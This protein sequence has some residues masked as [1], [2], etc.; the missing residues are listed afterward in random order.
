M[1]ETAFYQSSKLMRQVRGYG[2]MPNIAIKHFTLQE[3]NLPL[4]P[5]IARYRLFYQGEHYAAA[6]L[7]PEGIISPWSK[8]LLLSSRQERSGITCP[9]SA[10]LCTAFAFTC[11]L[12]SFL[13]FFPPLP[14]LPPLSSSFLPHLLIHLHVSNAWGKLH[15]VISS[16]SKLVS[17]D[18][19]HTASENA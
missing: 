7:L 10:A 18:L 2:H 1:Q 12:P 3:V 17:K 15:I 19:S 4:P 13:P 6:R 16:A 5:I 11:Q 9:H 8:H 14:N